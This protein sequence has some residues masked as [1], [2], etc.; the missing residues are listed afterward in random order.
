M[1]K[2]IKLLKEEIKKV[3][4]GSIRLEIIIHEGKITFIEITETKQKIKI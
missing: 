1:N 4:Y 2:V 3:R